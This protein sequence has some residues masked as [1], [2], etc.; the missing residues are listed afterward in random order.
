MKTKE[1]LLN[2]AADE[3]SGKLTELQEE[4]A[5]LKLQQATHQITNP[6]RIR[7][8]RHDIA[9]IKTMQTEYAQGIRVAKSE[10]KEK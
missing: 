8:I 7:S 6:L 2:L 1:A 9:R 3:L 4:M 10:E 5:N